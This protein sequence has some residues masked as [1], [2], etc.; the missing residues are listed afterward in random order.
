MCITASRADESAAL[1]L[2][3]LVDAIMICIFFRADVISLLFRQM[4]LFFLDLM[5]VFSLLFF[6]V[7]IY[8]R[9]VHWYYMFSVT[10][11]APPSCN[12]C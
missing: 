5:L 11:F 4:L 2:T 3:A 1:R 7:L 12:A 9:N 10:F 8:F 6:P